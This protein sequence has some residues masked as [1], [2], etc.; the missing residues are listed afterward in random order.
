MSK[1]KA[2]VKHLRRGN[3]YRR[4]DLEQWSKAVDRHLGEL[5]EDGTLQKLSQ[6]LYYYPKA[7]PFGYAP[8]DEKTLVRSFLKDDMFLLTSP[9][10]YNS[11]GVGTT[12]LY[13][14][15]VVYNHK[16]HGEFELGGRTFFFHIKP[17]FPK[18]LTTEFLLVDL[19][20]NHE[21][22]AEDLEDVLSKVQ[23]KAATMDLKKLQKAVKMYGGVKAKK[24]FRSVLNTSEQPQYAA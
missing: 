10:A 15:R 12:Q 21:T 3:V 19:V 9:N 16:R 22:L 7:T 2:L 17:R 8:P 24:V 14:K 18:T 11:L 20:N 1:L 6:G 13:N 4:A 5:L 23:S